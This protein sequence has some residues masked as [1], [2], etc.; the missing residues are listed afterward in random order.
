MHDQLQLFL[1]LIVSIMKKI[2]L[3]IFVVF[4][5]VTSQASNDPT[6]GWM[7]YFGNA[8]FNNTKLKANYD[9]QLRNHELVSDLNQLL[10][11]GS[12][13]YPIASN[14]TLG[15][16]YA[17]VLT[18]KMNEP[19]VP[20]NENRIYQDVLTQ[21]NVGTSSVL[22]H[23]FRFE[24]RFIENQDFKSRIRYQ[25]G[26]DVPFYK[27]EGKQTSAYATAYNEIFMNLDESSRK[28]NP[29]DRNRLFLGA[30]YKFNNDLGVQFG[31]MNQ[32]LQK[33]S[34]QQF[35][36]SLHHNIKL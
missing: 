17:H 19:D 29:F 26:V 30:G 20:F 7:M 2:I 35:M 8:T 11:R 36:F 22:K 10:I 32:M 3:S 15:A 9:V 25:L 14:L 21:Q 24:Q 28:H 6:G 5:S 18:E 23:R 27:N 12:L 31:W 13:Q 16:G 4:N 34:Y 33:Q 1:C